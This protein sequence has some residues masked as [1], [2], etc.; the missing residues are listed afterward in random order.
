M[1]RKIYVAI[2]VLIVMVM[3]V[4]TLGTACK[5]KPAGEIVIGI[6]NEMTGFMAPAGIPGTQGAQTM[7][8]MA[9]SQMAGRPIKVVIEDTATEPAVALDKARKLVEVDKACIIIGPLFGGTHLAIAPYMDK[10][11]VPSLTIEGNWETMALDNQWTWIVSGGLIQ[12]NY[13]FGIYAYDKL[14]YRTVTAIYPDM[15]GGPDFYEGFKRG[16]EERGGQMVQLQLFPAGTM[17]FSPY[18]LALKPADALFSFAVAAHV[19][20]YY[21]AVRELGVK[22]PILEGPGELG[23]PAVINELGDAVVGVIYTTS[24]LYPLDTP[25]NKEFVDAYQKQWGEL[26]AHLSGCAAAATQIALE[27]LRKT[28]GDTSG[29]ALAKALGETDMDTVRGRITMTPDRVGTMTFPIAEIVKVN[30]T[31]T[32]KILDTSRVKCERVGD[33]LTYTVV[34]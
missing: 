29:E 17:D 18:I 25:G 4:P 13:P 14:G 26:P 10:V 2:A 5:P 19:F 1:K 31:Y 27:A 32:Y 15:A 16:F 23:N 30:G 22:M 7:I 6:L 20:P 11:K 24:Y 33:K 8:Q 9:G 21:K 3:L 28:G 12:H 34:K